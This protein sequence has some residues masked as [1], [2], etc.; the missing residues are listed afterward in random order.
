MLAERRAPVPPAPGQQPWGSGLL[1][2]QHEASATRALTGSGREAQMH[3]AMA[4][5]VPKGEGGRLTMA[6]E[7][8]GSKRFP[9]AMGPGHLLP[10]PNVT[11]EN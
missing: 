8:G 5:A 11:I 6:P 10:L 4:H 3:R 1:C 2:R 9:R 7:K